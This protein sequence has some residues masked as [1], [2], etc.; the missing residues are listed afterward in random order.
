MSQFLHV[1]DTDD[2]S[3]RAMITPLLFS[4]EKAEL[5]GGHPDLVFLHNHT[6]SKQ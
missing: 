6:E 3:A 2:D 4:A 5:T 1:D